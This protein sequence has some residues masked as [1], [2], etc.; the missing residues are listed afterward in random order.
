VS[1]R[2]LFFALWPTQARQQALCA[3]T[4]A[5][6]QVSGGRAIGADSLHLTLAFLGPIP[7]CEIAS[8][9][10]AGQ[11]VAA[12]WRSRS[13]LET[14]LDTLNYWRKAQILCALA[15]E[16]GASLLAHELRQALVTGGFSPDPRPF[17]AH[18]TLARKVVRE[19]NDCTISPVIWP[20]TSFALIESRTDPRGAAYSIVDSW[21]LGET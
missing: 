3:A 4:Q 20:F 18:V 13:P 2:R 9:R 8:A 12:A 17:R 21:T 1:T 11:R 7:E 14:R 6:V 16:S 10:S 15:H 5:A 19:P